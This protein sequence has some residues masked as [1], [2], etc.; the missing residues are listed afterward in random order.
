MQ[1][2]VDETGSIKSR[3]ADGDGTGVPY[4]PYFRS[5]E[6]GLLSDAI[7][8]D[9]DGNHS[10]LSLFKR[11]LSEYS[12]FSL[13]FTTSVSTV[14]TTETV[15]LD[16]ETA[17]WKNLSLVIDNQGSNALD[18][19]RIFGTMASFGG[20]LLAGSAIPNSYSSG[21]AKQS[22]NSS[23]PIIDA[24]NLPTTGATSSGW[25][26]IN[27]LPYRKIVIDASTLSGSSTVSVEGILT[28]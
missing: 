14:T 16:I 12:I 13:P 19:V 11:F 20:A 10:L 9:N 22:N 27:C 24:F 15:I 2:Y 4:I 1:N 18:D 6:I 5:E 3:K 25:V 21:N 26:V 8:P 7:A 17:E 23:I 28:R